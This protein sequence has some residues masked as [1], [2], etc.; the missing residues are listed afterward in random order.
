MV[1][2]TAQAQVLP[3]STAPAQA[4]SLA[5][6]SLSQNSTTA[7][8]IC[9]SALAIS[10]IP[11]PSTASQANNGITVLG[12]NSSDSFINLDPRQAPAATRAPITDH[13]SSLA[14]ANAN[15]VH[16]FP[17]EACDALEQLST[18]AARITNNVP[19][20]QT[21]DQ[22][23]RAI[24]DQFQAQQLCVQWE[25]QEQVQSTN[26][27][28]AALAEQMQQLISTA[29]AVARNS[30]TPRPQPVTSR[31]HSKEMRD[32]Y[33]PNETLRET[34]QDLAFGRPPAHIKPEAPSTDTLYN[35]KF[36]RSLPGR[37]SATPTLAVNPFG[38][39]DYPPDDYYE[40]PQQWYDLSPISHREEDS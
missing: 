19:T 32:I 39:L 10:Q 15:K 4:N 40:H 17:I 6:P 12:T 24:S 38:F 31:F 5:P 8:A 36:S 21:I 9:A 35:H 20:V 3:I 11:P 7:A 2:G 25:I 18:T 14:I 37:A 28:F 33:I 13:C 34:E 22:I 26:A 29:M 1:D 27:R 30:P 23:I 16:N